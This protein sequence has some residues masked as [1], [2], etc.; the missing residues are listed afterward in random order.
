MFDHCAQV[1]SR[2]GEIHPR[3]PKIAMLL[4]VENRRIFSLA[5]CNLNGEESPEAAM[6]GGQ[7]MGKNNA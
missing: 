4:I 3:N 7:A 5:D 1:S 2:Y 6:A